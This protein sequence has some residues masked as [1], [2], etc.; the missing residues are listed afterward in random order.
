M[1]RGMLSVGDQVRWDERTWT[2]AILEGVRGRL[3][4]DSGAVAAVSLPH[5]FADPHFEVC[6]APRRQVPPF[7]L[8]AELSDPVR[9]RALSWGGTYERWKRVSLTRWAGR[10]GRSTTLRCIPWRSGRRPRPRN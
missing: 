1:K 5:L 7:A 4:D 8:L 6:G 2:V 3:V 10:R 9:E